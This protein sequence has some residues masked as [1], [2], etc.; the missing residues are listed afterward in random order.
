MSWRIKSS[1]IGAIAAGLVFS[2]MF[3][4]VRCSPSPTEPS[5]ECV[6]IRSDVLSNLK[7]GDTEEMALQFFKQRA[8]KYAHGQALGFYDVNLVAGRKGGEDH[9]VNVHIEVKYGLIFYISVKD[10]YIAF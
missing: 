7:V 3:F 5:S 1:I 6:V 10:I 2:A 9:Q 8:W 4:V